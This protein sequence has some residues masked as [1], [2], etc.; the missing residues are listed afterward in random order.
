MT[1]F[2]LAFQSIAYEDSWPYKGPIINWHSTTLFNFF[3]TNAYLMLID[4]K[5]ECHSISAGQ[6]RLM[7]QSSQCFPIQ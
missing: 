5:K 1:E 6:R 4:R 2:L 3:L 7:P